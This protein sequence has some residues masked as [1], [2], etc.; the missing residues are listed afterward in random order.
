MATKQLY[1][2]SPE[3]LASG[4]NLDGSD[5]G[6]C[7][8]YTS[9]ESAKDDAHEL[10]DSCDIDDMEEAIIYKLVPILSISRAKTQYAEKKL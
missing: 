2:T 4:D 5:L 7:N 10:L 1:V 3:L 9:L 8:L 6:E